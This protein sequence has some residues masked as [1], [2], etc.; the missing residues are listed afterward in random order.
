MA[1]PLPD[2]PSIA[3]LPFVNMSE[4]P[5]QEYLAD[6]LTENIITALSRVPTLFVIARNS[7]FT[8]KGKRV[9]VQKVAE[10]LGVRYI[11]E[12]SVQR[13]E[14]RVRITAQL[15]D[16]IDGKHLWA[17]KYDRVLKD[18]FALQDEITMKII[19][20][21]HVKLTDLVEEGLLA[22]GTNN[23]EAYLTFIEGREIY[24][25]M[26]KEA[27]L[28]GRELFQEAIALDPEY[29]SV[30]ALLG[31]T[32]ASEA[33]MGYS[34]SFRES[35]ERALELAQKAI[36]LD[37]NNHTG[38]LLLS[39][40]YRQRRQLEKS[41][42][43]MERLINL[44][45]ND[46]IS[47]D[48]LA[49]RLARLGRGEEAIRA[50]KKAI[51]LN[52]MPQWW[53]FVHLGNA[54]WVIEQ[55]DEALAAYKEAKRRNPNLHAIR[56]WLAATHSLLGRDEEARA[57]AAEVLRLKPDFSA[58]AWAKREVFKDQALTERLAN[59]LHKAGLK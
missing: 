55:Y 40:I 31:W 3:V 59:A 56:I 45:P 13:S 42:A 52:P 16:A 24:R 23:L 26:T 41:L 34:K 9:K 39:Y 51:R 14:D 27:I 38:R 18:L 2:K 50:A 5:K 33:R 53:Y 10:D 54:H 36:A 32:H 43:E 11:V 29:A 28:G 57:E 8:Y 20:A 1:F 35:N 21:L 48:N 12:G 6:G 25:P 7:T 44:Y 15:I 49:D 4:D 19:I 37:E 22:R 47:Y 58:D 30:Y 46:E 17:K